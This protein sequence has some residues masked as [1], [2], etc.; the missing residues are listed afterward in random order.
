MSYTT[1]SPRFMMNPCRTFGVNVLGHFWI[2]KAF[3]P[4]MLEEKSGHIVRNPFQVKLD[5]LFT[6]YK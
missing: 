2:L 4:H 5:N 1:L 3:L 6:I